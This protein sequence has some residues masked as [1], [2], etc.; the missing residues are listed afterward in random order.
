MYHKTRILDRKLR[1]DTAYYEPWTGYA[2][3]VHAT[4]LRR[5][6]HSGW[7]ELS[8]GFQFVYFKNVRNT[9]N[10]H[11]WSKRPFDVKA[12]WEEY[13]FTQEKPKI[14]QCFH[15]FLFSTTDGD[16]VLGIDLGIDRVTW[17]MFAY[18][19]LSRCGCYFGLITWCPS[20][21]CMNGAEKL[22]WGKL[23]KY[24]VNFISGSEWSLFFITTVPNW[25]L[26]HYNL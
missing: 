19:M 15:K 9:C 2:P 20:C 16:E 12:M 10:A 14:A 4:C 17:I 1:C 13:V 5:T 22:L 7:C 24:I 25:I 23:L 3:D 21:P 11:I 6:R 18:Q 26:K 8:R